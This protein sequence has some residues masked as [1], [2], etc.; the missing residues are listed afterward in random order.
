ML[1]L[2]LPFMAVFPTLLAIAFGIRSGEENS[3]WRIALAIACLRL[4]G[5]ALSPAEAPVPFASASAQPGHP[6][7]LLISDQCI[8]QKACQSTI[9]TLVNAKQD[10]PL[11]MTS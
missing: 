6:P 3:S 5:I 4:F 2:T 8:P 11:L 10:G 9:E 7:S 1:P